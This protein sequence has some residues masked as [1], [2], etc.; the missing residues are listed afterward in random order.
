M[1]EAKR[2]AAL[3][4]AGEVKPGEPAP[5]MRSHTWTFVMSEQVDGQFEACRAYVE[6]RLR[7]AARL[8]G[9]SE[10][11]ANKITV[12]LADLAERVLAAG[13]QMFV[14]QIAAEKKREQVIW[15][16]ESAAEASARLQA[17][18]K[19]GGQ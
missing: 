10:E 16:P 12:A 8:E 13:L 15:T 4:A 3:V 19:E 11:D 6:E 14:S 1:G 9:R 5:K 2:R 18:K 17:L 7:K